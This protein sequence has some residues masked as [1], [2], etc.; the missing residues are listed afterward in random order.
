MRRI[1]CVVLA[2]HILAS[3]VAWAV[4]V[5][6]AG[7]AVE[8]AQQAT[9][10]Q[11]GAPCQDGAQCGMCFVGCHVPTMLPSQVPIVLPD[12]RQN[13]QSAVIALAPFESTAPPLP[14]PKR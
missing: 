11:D 10:T 9:E 1:L 7:G 4:D 14:P 5:H 12:W 6:D 2:F 8:R 3:S 13:P